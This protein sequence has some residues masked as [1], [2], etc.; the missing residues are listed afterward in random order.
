MDLDDPAPDLKYVD[1]EEDLVEMG[2]VGI[3][4]EDEM[5]TELLVTIGCLGMDGAS[6]LHKYVRE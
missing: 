6:R 2:L 3:V 1:I 5:P 4:E